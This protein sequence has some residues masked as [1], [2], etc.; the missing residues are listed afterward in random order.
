MENEQVVDVASD[1]DGLLCVVDRFRTRE[2]TGVG[3]ALGET[4]LFKPWKQRTLPP[5]PSLSHA[6]DRFDD[7][8]DSGSSVGSCGL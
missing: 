3:S 8:A 5:A 4:P 6:V 2:H 7:A 1:D